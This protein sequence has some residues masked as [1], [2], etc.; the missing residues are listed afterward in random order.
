MVNSDSEPQ[1]LQLDRIN[2]GVARLLVHWDIQQV[3]RVDA[4]NGQI[5]T[6]WEYQEKVIPWILDQPYATT[7]SVID[8]LLSIEEE[9][10]NYAKAARMVYGVGD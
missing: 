6:S 10:V 4:M 2:N 1:T 8:Y 9:I 7:Q 5:R 3:E